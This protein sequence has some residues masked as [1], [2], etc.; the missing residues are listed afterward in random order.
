MN[1][2]FFFIFFSKDTLKELGT[3]ILSMLSGNSLP[4]S[5]SYFGVVIKWDSLYAK[6]GSD[7]SLKCCLTTFWVSPVSKIG[8]G[9]ECLPLLAALCCWGTQIWT[10]AA[11]QSQMTAHMFICPR[12]MNQHSRP[13]LTCD[14]FDSWVPGTCKVLVIILRHEFLA[15]YFM[16]TQK[17]I[18]LFSPSG[19]KCFQPWSWLQCFCWHLQELAKLLPRLVYAPLSGKLRDLYISVA[20][21]WQGWLCVQMLLIRDKHLEGL[22]RM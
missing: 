6:Q 10:K 2:C 16:N 8:L 18:F 22:R 5:H 1:S 15:S 4:Q 13:P 3:Y 20:H 12:R 17:Q 19:N 11:D 7:M 9:V 14:T 21:C